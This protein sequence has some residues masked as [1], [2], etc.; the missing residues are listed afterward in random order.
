[1]IGESEVNDLDVLNSFFADVVG[2]EQVTALLLEHYHDVFRLK[3]PVDDFQRVQIA[4]GLDDFTDDEGRHEFRK[5]FPF[6]DVLVKILAI[7]VFSDD[8]D[9][10]FTS[11]GVVIAYNL[12]VLQQLHY[13]GFVLKDHDGL[14]IQFLS[15]NVLEGV[16][17][18][19]K[20]VRTS[21]DDGKLASTYHFVD[22]IEVVER[23]PLKD[24]K[25]LKDRVHFCLGLK[26]YDNAWVIFVSVVQLNSE[27]ILVSQLAHVEA[28]EA[29]HLA[30]GPP[31]L[32][33]VRNDEYV[34]NHHSI[35]GLD[36]FALCHLSP[37]RPIYL[38]QK[39]RLSVVVAP[40][41]FVKVGVVA[42]KQF[43]VGSYP[44]IEL[45]VREA[46]INLGVHASLDID[47]VVLVDILRKLLEQRN[48][49]AVVDLV[50]ELVH[51]ELQNSTWVLVLVEL[52]V[53][54]PERCHRFL[55]GR[56]LLV[57]HLDHCFLLR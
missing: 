25:D 4:H 29:N 20:L 30:G 36:L 56:Q 1:M 14:R 24:L 53:V 22:V 12:R 42:L 37:E 18:A 39:D 33:A 21:V 19:S 17:L 38:T 3:V 49:I 31:G 28:V 6:A 34:S 43:G 48:H 11:D 26:I 8:V 44:G 10:F 57:V 51:F 7:Y 23:V 50:C 54:S 5:S 32:V 15:R 40:Y 27:A 2:A 47:V 35:D 9:V 55:L 52:R 16:A 46:S 45:F 41:T 13:F